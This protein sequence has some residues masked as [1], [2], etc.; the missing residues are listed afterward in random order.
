M[1]MDCFLKRFSHVLLNDD[2]DAIFQT[3]KIL[4]GGTTSHRI[5]RLLNFA[6]S[7][8]DKGECYV[9]TGVFAGGTLISA[10]WANGKTCIGIDS[11]GPTINES[12]HAD[13]TVIRD[14]ARRNIQMMAPSALLIEKDFRLVTKEEIPLPVAVSFIDARHTYDDVY[15]N[16]VWLEPLLADDALIIFDDVNYR[17]VGQAIDKW[18]TE[19]AS[20]YDLTVYIKPFYQDEKYLSSVEDRGL[21]NGLCV[22][23]YHR[24][25]AAI[26]A[27]HLV[28]QP[29]NKE[30]SA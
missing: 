30:A 1:N 29:E 22:I 6:V 27:V 26:G 4:I 7:Q 24:N 25:P 5:A 9:E 23:R 28:N 17:G 3:L 16:L 21:N 15:E 19:H 11:Y 2:N 13:P 20:N 8:M 18:L 12:T 10:H 14:V